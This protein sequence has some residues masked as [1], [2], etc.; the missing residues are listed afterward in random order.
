M[1][2][3]NDSKKNNKPFKLRKKEKQFLLVSFFWCLLL[4]ILF[5]AILTI[6]FKNKNIEDIGTT[7]GSFVG[8]F[9]TFF[10]SILVYKALKS[11]IKANRIISEQFKIQQFENQF[12]QMLNLHKEN[13]N[14]IEIEAI[15]YKYNGN[16]FN[17]GN[18]SYE[19]KNIKIKGRDT[20]IY[21]C[22]ELEIS[23]NIYKQYLKENNTNEFDFTIPYKAFFNG[24]DALDSPNIEDYYQINVDSFEATHLV[25][26]ESG[27]FLN[28]KVKSYYKLF[29]G[30]ENKLGHYYRHLFHMVKFVAEQKTSFIPYEEKRKYLR[31]LRAQ[32]SNFEQAMLFYNYL[33]YAE[34]WEK[35][36]K[37][38]TNYRMIHNLYDSAIISDTYFK[39]ELNKL[40]SKQTDAYCYKDNDHIFEFQ[41]WENID[42]KCKNY[43]KD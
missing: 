17:G 24:I 25:N 26:F 33:A 3:D 28:I 31:L 27:F 4:S 8:I 30:H 42:F 43:P 2:K 40:K 6:V 34:E 7:F 41:R 36:N 20:F 16:D 15:E 23:Y 13:V 22:N 10:G 9:V 37:F 19:H 29:E 14:E 11:Q 39:N 21:F 38:F 35:D 18:G 32:L 5:I 12:Y 1:K